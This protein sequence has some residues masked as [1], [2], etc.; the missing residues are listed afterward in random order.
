M[1]LLKTEN[2]L[3]YVKNRDIYKIEN[4][5]QTW[6]KVSYIL[7]KTISLIVKRLL[8]IIYFLGY[9]ALNLIIK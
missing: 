1:K 9:Y 4:I 7:G 8:W 5:S 2:S 3:S 6:F